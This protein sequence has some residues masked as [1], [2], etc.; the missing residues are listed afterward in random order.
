[1]A[2][3][4]VSPSIVVVRPFRP[5]R[6]YNGWSP[7]TYDE[8]ALV[9]VGHLVDER[10]GVDIRVVAAAGNGGEP[11]LILDRYTSSY[12][13]LRQDLGQIRAQEADCRLAVCF[14]AVV[15]SRQGSSGFAAKTILQRHTA[16][17]L[18][19]L[20]KAKSVQHVHA[21]G[22]EVESCS[23]PFGIRIGFVHRGRDARLL[24]KERGRRTRDAAAGS[25]PSACPRPR[26]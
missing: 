24:E 2:I 22:G 8:E 6:P 14:A 15:V 3:V 21:V 7:Y 13:P 25:R 4:A 20:G 1:M 10:P 5:S 18:N 19:F 9:L 16:T 12:H 26:L 11:F 23:H 17:R